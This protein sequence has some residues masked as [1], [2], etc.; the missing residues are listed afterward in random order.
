MIS[1][2]DLYMA[3]ASYLTGFLR[4]LVNYW[5]LKLIIDIISQLLRSY[6]NY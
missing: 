6:P 2:I 4:S 5:D 3:L 1:I